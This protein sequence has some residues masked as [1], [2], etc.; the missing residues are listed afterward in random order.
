MWLTREICIKA[1]SNLRFLEGTKELFCRLW[2]TRAKKSSSNLLPS[3]AGISLSSFVP[4]VEVFFDLFVLLSLLSR[5]PVGRRYLF[6]YKVQTINVHK[7][8]GATFILY[9]ALIKRSRRLIDQ[10]VFMHCHQ[11]L[12]VLPLKP[13][14]TS[15]WPLRERQKVAPHIWRHFIENRNIINFN[16]RWKK[17]TLFSGHK[18]SKRLNLWKTD[19]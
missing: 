12:P 1:T 6:L 4:P 15:L 8:H 5:L 10:R 18:G 14:L 17:S 2:N 13:G 19:S 7:Y 9:L 3:F 11:V 16:F